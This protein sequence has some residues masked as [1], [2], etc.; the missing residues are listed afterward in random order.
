[1]YLVTNNPSPLPP[2]PI[3]LAPINLKVGYRSTHST[4]A[5]TYVDLLRL[6]MWRVLGDPNTF[7]SHS[8]RHDKC[9]S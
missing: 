9:T 4:H 5:L 1:M 8:S 3:I 2:Q 6:V 7:T